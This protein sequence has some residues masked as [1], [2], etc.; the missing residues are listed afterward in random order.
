MAAALERHEF[1]SA[2]FESETLNDGWVGESR[3]AY[4]DV[5]LNNSLGFLPFAGGGGLGVRR[6]VFERVGGFDDAHRRSSE[7][8]DFCWRVQLAGAELHFVPD[9]IVRIAWRR[10]LRELYRQGRHYGRGEPYLY[11][12]YRHAGMPRSS[13]RTGLVE[14]RLLLRRLR[15]VRGKGTRHGGC[16]C[17]VDA[18]G[19]CKAV[20]VTGSS[21]SDNYSFEPRGTL[22]VGEER[23]NP[24]LVNTAAKSS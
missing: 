5:G 20:S 13:L 4:Q 22:A 2:A 16:A 23:P 21:T 7:D 19:A 15:R 18:S 24:I 9:A 12:K 11:R 14:W 17:S 6:E 8:I 10:H 1:V 3:R